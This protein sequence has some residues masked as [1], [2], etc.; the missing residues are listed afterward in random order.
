MS[1]LLFQF[2]SGFHC[3]LHKQVGH[4]VQAVHFL[5]LQA[6]AVGRIKLNNNFMFFM[7]Y[8]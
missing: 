8:T 3:Q 5:S 1:L 2:Q 4:Q 7:E 6:E